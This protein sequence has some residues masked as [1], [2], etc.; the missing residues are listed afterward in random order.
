MPANRA[1]L[2]ASMGWDRPPR[3]VRAGPPPPTR[4]PQHVNHPQGKGE[5]RTLL[6]SLGQ[7]KCQLTTP[8]ATV[9]ERTPTIPSNPLVQAAEPHGPHFSGDRRS[10]CQLSPWTIGLEGTIGVRFLTGAAGGFPDSACRGFA[11]VLRFADTP[12]Q[13]RRRMTTL[14]ERDLTC[15]LCG[16]T[17]TTNLVGSFSIG[18]KESDF[19]PR[20]LGMSPLPFFVHDCPGCGYVGYEVDFEPIDAGRIVEKLT[21][22]LKGMAQ[23]ERLTGLDKYRRMAILGVERGSKNVEI[24]DAY[25]KASWCARVEGLDGGREC[26][27]KAIRYFELALAANEP[28]RDEKPVVTYLVG[29]LC[30]RVGRVEPARKWLTKVEP[31]ENVPAWLIDWRDAALNKLEQPDAAPEPTM[32]AAGPTPTAGDRPGPEPAPESG[33]A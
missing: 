3:T 32:P 4:R 20:Y 22:A 7:W 19:C 10:R 24:A 30:R 27:E 29:E 28:S 6:P 5:P 23:G 9:R 16:S 18:E 21:K 1:T 31:G 12:S 33:E 15:P 13:R 8:A 2:A 25:L 17:F 26:Q 11:R 14:N